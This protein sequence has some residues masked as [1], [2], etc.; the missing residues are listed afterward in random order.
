M[1][2]EEESCD[3]KEDSRSA[4][5]FLEKK[6]KQPRCSGSSRRQK[7]VDNSRPPVIK[8]LIKSKVRTHFGFY[9]LPGKT[10]TI[11]PLDCRTSE[12]LLA[13]FLVKERSLISFEAC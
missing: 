12:F 1:H 6:K 4:W 5:L 8:I 9:T 7:M 10:V 3:M 2:V 13:S 11:T